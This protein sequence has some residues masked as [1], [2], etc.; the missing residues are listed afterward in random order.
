M[1]NIFYYNNTSGTPVAKWP[2]E[3]TRQGGKSRKSGQLYL[4]RVI[5]KE[6]HIFY[7]RGEGYYIFD[8]SDQSRKPIAQED[9]PA[10]SG[11][12]DGRER[13]QSVCCVFGGSYFLSRL[14]PGIGYHSVLEKIKYDNRDT[15][16]SLL[17]Y[18][19]LTDTADMHAAYWYKNSYSSFLYPHANMAGQRISDLYKAVGAGDNRRAFLE[20]HI[21]YVTGSTDDEYYVLVD[22]TGCP[23]ACDIPITKVSRHENEVNIEF[24]AIVV[25]QQST[26]LPIYY[27]IIPGNIVDVS[28][29]GNILRKLRLYG[30]KVKYVLGDAGYCCPGTME[31]LILSGIEFMTRMNPTYDLYRK[32]VEEHYSEVADPGSTNTVRYRGRLVKVI[33]VPCVIGRDRQ[34]GDEKTG[35]IYLCR[36][37]QSYHSKADHLM[38]ASHARTMTS[39]EIAK[40]VSR[41]GIF[42]IVSTMDLKPEDVLPEYY[43]RQGVEQFFDYAKNYGKMIPVRNHSVETISGHMLL[44]FITTFICTLLK[45]RMNILDTRYVAIPNHLQGEVGSD[46]DSVECE[47]AD[48]KKQL[49]VS[50]DP[51]ELVFRPSPGMLFL[52]LQMQSAE[53]FDTEIVPAVPTREVND[54][55]GAFGLNYPV[56]VM[57]ENGTVL[58]VLKED[59]RDRCSRT[60]IFAHKPSVSD[61]AI[62]A[63]RKEKSKKHLEQLAA[64]HEIELSPDSGRPEEAPKRKPGRPPGSKNRKTLEREELIRRLTEQGM[65]PVKRGRGRPPG[66]RNKKTLEREALEKEQA[67]KRGRGRPP[68]SKNKKTHEQKERERANAQ[69]CLSSQLPDTKSIGGNGS[70]P[71]K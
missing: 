33:K 38:K 31:R 66:S 65:Q 52:S 64:E 11:P 23:N 69:E 60:K 49:V 54:F 27:E 1:I 70:G 22:S 68:G 56:T 40:A 10:Y 7:K 67:K 25:V 2:G 63:K 20:A 42:A 46:E 59:C 61:E 36:D 6:K 21:K 48:G 57:R 43:T 28:T 13:K 71:E 47:T 15:F 26:G 14:I 58:P 37:I 50:Q 44:A 5:N 3:G 12:V 41:F 53:I 55:F 32:T 24:R 45:N 35:F 39:E 62:E 4:G 30:C 8:P 19:L 9:I 51:L 16:N 34:T 18:Y 29:L 17:Q